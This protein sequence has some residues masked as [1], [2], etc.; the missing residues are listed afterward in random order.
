MRVTG[1]R[2]GARRL[3][4]ALAAVALAVAV[5]P[6][7]AAGAQD[8]VS[9]V[10]TAAREPAS[11]PMSSTLGSTV[12]VDLT[13]AASQAGISVRTGSWSVADGQLTAS[14]APEAVGLID[15]CEGC[16]PEREAVT[17][18][19]VTMLVEFPE[20]NPADPHVGTFLGVGFEESA[21]RRRGVEF[22][23]APW[24][25]L[26]NRGG[27]MVVRGFVRWR[28]SGGARPAQG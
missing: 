8:R 23:L 17:Q 18:A 15:L 27:G 11:V 9:T 14:A 12:D 26:T 21:G 28:G 20:S 16:D 10:D 6:L 7:G 3:A 19:T 4:G 1:S 5:C 13:G 2:L 25:P 24:R 22:Q